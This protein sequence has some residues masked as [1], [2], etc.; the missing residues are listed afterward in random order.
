MKTTVITFKT[1][2]VKDLIADT[3]NL[4]EVSRHGRKILDGSDYVIF[5]GQFIDVYDDGTRV[6]HFGFSYYD[7]Q[8]EKGYEL[9][10]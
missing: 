3:I 4:D 6:Y 8:D 2:S 9:I 5:N 10:G 7:G 1:M